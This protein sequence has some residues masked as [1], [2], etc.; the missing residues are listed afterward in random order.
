MF[1]MFYFFLYEVLDG[2]FISF[3]EDTLQSMK[4]FNVY[5]KK[6]ITF[7]NRK[8]YFVFKIT[9]VRNTKS[10]RKSLV[11]WHY[12]INTALL[13]CNLLQIIIHKKIIMHKHFA[14]NV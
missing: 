13:L 12:L 3:F 8:L 2:F 14:N 5:I 7:Q 6:N 11:L 4:I 9:L 1:G 10:V